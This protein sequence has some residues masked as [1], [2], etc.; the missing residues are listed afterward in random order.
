MKLQTAANHLLTA[1]HLPPG[2]VNVLPIPVDEGGRLIIWID[3]RYLLRAR[4]LPSSYE[5]YKVSVE[6]RPE[7][8]T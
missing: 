1:L 8:S 5:G 6:A 2:T 3:S 7:I 4:D